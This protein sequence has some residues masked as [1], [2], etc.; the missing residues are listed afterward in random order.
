[1]KI[2]FNSLYMLSIVAF[3]NGCTFYSITNPQKDMA[4][5]L[6]PGVKE[7]ESEYKAKAEEF[8]RYA[9]SGDADS[10]VKITS[11]LTI[12]KNDGPT[13]LKS[14]FEEKIIP[15]FLGIDVKWKG[16][17]KIGYG[18]DYDVGF[19]FEGDAICGE[20]AYKF[21]VYVYE[22]HEELVVVFMR[23]R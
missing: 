5:F 17:G 21:S 12:Q 22:E 8:V 9:Q 7:R 2:P 3:L 1:M 20:K 13:V 10:M 23:E 4:Q 18:E 14:K 6:I 11:P 19:A 16:Q 15:K